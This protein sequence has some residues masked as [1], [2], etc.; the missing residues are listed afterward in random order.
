MNGQQG[1]GAGG[2][3][4]GRDAEL[5]ACREQ[6]AQ[7]H[8]ELEETN[9]GLIALHAELEAARQAEAQLAAI[10]HASD[11]AMFSMT[12]DGVIQTWNRGA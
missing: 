5:A 10:V 7:L 12:P 2:A 11:D 3:G 9:R 4:G 1:G 8:R 6:I